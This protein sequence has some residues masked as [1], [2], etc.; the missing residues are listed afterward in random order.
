MV[1]EAMEGSKQSNEDYEKSAAERREREEMAER[2]SFVIKFNHRGSLTSLDRAQMSRRNS[3]SADF[4][5]RQSNSQIKIIAI[6]GSNLLKSNLELNNMYK[7]SQS[8]F[9]Y[10]KTSV[11]QLH[12][13]CSK[14]SD[15]VLCSLIINDVL[16][17]FDPF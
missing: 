17:L 10:Y 2:L 14:V 8:S 7:L 16:L 15:V 13:L 4:G 5:S 11:P 3:S 6:D 1:A 9:I 12:K